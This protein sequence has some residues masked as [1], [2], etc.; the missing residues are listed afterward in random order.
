MSLTSQDLNNDSIIGAPKSLVFLTENVGNTSLLT[1]STNQVYA[2]THDGVVH[3][4]SNSSGT[5]VQRSYSN[6]WEILGVE[7]VNGTNQLA[8][9]NTNGSYYRWTLDQNW[10][11]VSGQ[12]MAGVTPQ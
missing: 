1:D 3:S 5:A 8:W 9:K 4:I 7:T 11:Q 2:K 10:N 6:G 12:S